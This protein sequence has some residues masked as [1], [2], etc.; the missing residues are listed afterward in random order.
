MIDK[1]F[2]P[3]DEILT[4]KSV[5]KLKEQI[6]F[7]DRA[8]K[9]NFCARLTNFLSLADFMTIN[10]LHAVTRDSFVDLATIFDI[11]TELGPSFEKLKTHLDTSVEI[12]DPRPD[13]APQ[14]PFLTAELVLRPNNVEVDPSRDVTCYIVTQMITLILEAIH[15]VKPFQSDPHFTLFTEPSIVGHQE[16]KLYKNPPSIDFMLTT[17][18]DL[19]VNKKSII[20][21]I[22]VAYDKVEEYVKRFNP[23]R[24]AYREDVLMDKDK[25]K[26]EK[27]LDTLIAYCQR[28]TNEMNSL[29]GLLQYSNLGLMQLKQGTF[30]EEII[31]TCRDLLAILEEHL[32]K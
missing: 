30:K 4:C 11:H 6:S 15:H 27:D 14:F 19:N 16:E 18:E 10:L 28:Y 20:D 1:G 22:N 31:P 32:P 29:E 23:I 5:K 17:D 13:G 21:N 7:T 8:N 9:R 26:A 24:E 3:E 2:S 12:E 25:L